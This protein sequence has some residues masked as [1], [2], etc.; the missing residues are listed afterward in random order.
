M[1]LDIDKKQQGLYQNTLLTAIIIT[2]V[3]ILLITVYSIK[4]KNNDSCGIE[5]KKQYTT[6]TFVETITLNH[7]ND[8]ALQATGV[9][10]NGVKKEFCHETIVNTTGTISIALINEH[11]TVLGYGWLNNAS[12]NYCHEILLADDTTNQYIGIKCL[13]CDTNNYLELKQQYAGAQNQ[14]VITNIG[15]VENAEYQQPLSYVTKTYLNC[16]ETIKTIMDI[17]LVFLAGIFLIIMILVGYQGFKKM[18]FK[19]W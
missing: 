18:L 14:L 8:Y 3:A 9:L 4:Q 15:G 2:I 1:E 11:E 19:D 10:K 16:R 7:T 13:D 17:Y 5:E 6:T 12:T